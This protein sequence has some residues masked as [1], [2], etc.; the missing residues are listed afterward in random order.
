MSTKE[1]FRTATN[2]IGSARILRSHSIFASDEDD[3]VELSELCEVFSSLAAKTKKAY[4]KLKLSRMLKQYE[5]ALAKSIKE[6]KASLESKYKF[7]LVINKYEKKYIKE[8]GKDAYEANNIKE[9]ATF[10]E[11]EALNSLYEKNNGVCLMPK[12]LYE[13][14]Q[15]ALERDTYLKKSYEKVSSELKKEL[16]ENKPCLHIAELKWKMKAI[17]TKLRENEDFVKCLNTAKPLVCNF[18]QLNKSITKSTDK[19][20]VI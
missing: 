7:V 10:E 9:K 3:G 2:N 5:P 18:K 11:L 20:L 13:K 8:F 16:K 15:Y 1:H 4:R 19:A 17:R 14:L 6:G 12:D